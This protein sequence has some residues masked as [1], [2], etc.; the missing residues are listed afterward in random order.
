MHPKDVADSHH[1]VP[2]SRARLHPPCRRHELPGR[3]GYLCLPYICKGV[4]ITGALLVYTS[5]KRPNGL[6][7]LPQL[8][9]EPCTSPHTR[10]AAT[11]STH[12][13]FAQSIRC[14]LALSR[15]THLPIGVQQILHTSK[16]RH[17][18]P[19]WHGLLDRSL[20]FPCRS[21][22]RSC[23]SRFHTRISAGASR[24]CSLPAAM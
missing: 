6:R 24:A 8:V 1:R 2:G 3:V 11:V 14:D 5:L 12:A 23:K 16:G 21:P 4:G 13:S 10:R 18:L 15:L 19:P 9:R 20:V 7:I 22:G 17:Q